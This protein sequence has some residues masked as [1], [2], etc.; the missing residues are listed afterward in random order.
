MN[1]NSITFT[2]ASQNTDWGLEFESSLWLRKSRKEINGNGHHS[3]TDPVTEGIL[4]DLQ[5][6]DTAIPLGHGHE[7]Q[8]NPPRTVSLA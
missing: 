8:V 7:V 3:E 2:L 4:C 6:R 5:P 1:R